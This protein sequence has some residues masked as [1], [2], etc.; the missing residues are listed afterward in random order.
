MATEFTTHARMV[1]KL[2]Q[3]G[4]T[5]WTDHNEVGEVD[6]TVEND[7][8][9]R[10]T[11]EVLLHTDSRYDQESLAASRLV[12]AWATTIACYFLGFNRGMVPPDGLQIEFDMIMSDLRA[13]ANGKFGLPI[14]MRADLRPS[15]SNRE[16][17][18]RFRRRTVRVVK[19]SSTVDFSIL[20]RD[21]AVDYPTLD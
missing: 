11:D 14:T 2:S 16:V 1:R 7:A 9:Y 3:F 10:A 18:R 15:M 5:E 12:Q 4:V 13:V 17:D 20:P 21:W 6:T 19:E 8:I